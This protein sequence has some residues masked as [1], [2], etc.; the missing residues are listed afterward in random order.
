[1]SLDKSVSD[2]STRLPESSHR[3]RILPEFLWRIYVELSWVQLGVLE[4]K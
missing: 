4:L 2:T 1:M 3:I